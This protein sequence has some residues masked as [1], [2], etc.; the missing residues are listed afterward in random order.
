MA[1]SSQYRRDGPGIGQIPGEEV[2]SVVDAVE[3][4]AAV[5]DTVSMVS[6]DE[7][8]LIDAVTNDV[9]MVDVDVVELIDVVP[10]AVEMVDVVVVELIDAVPIA[11]IPV[12]D[13]VKLV[14]SVAD[15]EELV[16][17]VTEV[18]AAEI[19]LDGQGRIMDVV[20]DKRSDLM[21]FMQYA[22]DPTVSGF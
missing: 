14:N 6:V 18:G 17:G 20:A 5:V 22:N 1:S 13:V 11:L 15:A 4:V 7:L 21:N 12:D 10:N 16:A 19:E 9:E 3:T 2:I 8:E